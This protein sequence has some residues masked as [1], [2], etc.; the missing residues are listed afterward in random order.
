MRPA[1]STPKHETTLKD[2]RDERKAEDQRLY[3]L[4]M[5]VLEKLSKSGE[6]RAA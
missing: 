6:I 4:Q 2:V 5:K 1:P 3:K